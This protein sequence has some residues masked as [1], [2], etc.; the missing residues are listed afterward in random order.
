M[1]V[2]LKANN[3]LIYNDE[4]EFSM[5]ANLHHKRFKNNYANQGDLNVL[6]TAILEK[7]AEHRFT[8]KDGVTEKRMM[9]QIGG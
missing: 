2:S 3:L 1:L 8:E 6:K 4:I 5:Q 7:P 9:S